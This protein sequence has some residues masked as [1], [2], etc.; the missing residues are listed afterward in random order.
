ME[1]ATKRNKSVT[2]TDLL[3]LVKGQYSGDPAFA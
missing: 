3:A 1:L 2:K